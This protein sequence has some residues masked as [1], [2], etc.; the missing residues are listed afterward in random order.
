[1][2]STLRGVTLNSRSLGLGVLLMAASALLALRGRPYRGACYT[3]LSLS[4]IMLLFSAAPPDVLRTLLLTSAV[5]AIVY[6]VAA[7]HVATDAIRR[8]LGSATAEEAPPDPP[9]AAVMQADAVRFQLLE[10]ADDA[11]IIWE[12][13]GRGIQY[14]NPA[15]ER[16]YGFSFHD[17]KGK[18]THEL[19]HTRVV[20]TGVTELETQIAK[21]GMWIGE[22]VHRNHRGELIEVESRLSLISQEHGRWL[23][24]EVNRALTDRVAASRSQREAELR[25]VDL[26]RRTGA[27]PS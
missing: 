3:L 19:L 27:L 16:L 1:M 12:M 15:A 4:A 2:V 24:L 13:D 26:R 10:H 17:A 7:P 9:G 5:A 11:V 23:V 25:L 20:G 6:C 22:L 8:L 21:Y 18:V 14:W